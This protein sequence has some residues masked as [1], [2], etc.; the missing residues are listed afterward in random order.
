MRRNKPHDIA[1]TALAYLVILCIFCAGGA[2]LI[3]WIE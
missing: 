1:I 3:G 2:Y